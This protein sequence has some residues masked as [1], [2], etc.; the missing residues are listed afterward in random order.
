MR[1]GFCSGP[2]AKSGWQSG[3]SIATDEQK[4]QSALFDGFGNRGDAV[5]V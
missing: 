3:R 4:R 1:K 5:P 2:L